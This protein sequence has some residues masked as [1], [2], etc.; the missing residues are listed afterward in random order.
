C[1]GEKAIITIYNSETGMQ[2]QLVDEDTNYIGSPIEGNGNNLSLEV[3]SQDNQTYRVL[4]RPN[5]SSCQVF[6]EQQAGIVVIEQPNVDVEIL[7]DDVCPGSKETY[8]ITNSGYVIDWTTSGGTLL[9]QSDDSITIAWNNGNSELITGVITGFVYDTLT[10]CGDTIQ[11]EI[12]ISDMEPPI[13]VCKEETEVNASWQGDGYYYQI[14]DTSLLPFTTDNCGEVTLIFIDNYGNEYPASSWIGYKIENGE[15]IITWQATDIFGQ[16]AQ[17]TTTIR[18]ND[19]EYIP[20]A[21]SPNGDG[22]NDTWEIPF[23]RQE[24]Y[25]NAIVKVYNQHGRLVFESKNGYSQYWDG[26]YNG[27]N[28]PTDSYHYVIILKN[29]KEVKK[30]TVSITK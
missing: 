5:G 6:M 10:N 3:S 23:L 1:Y 16:R 15:N 29:Q 9:Y 28:L 18:L 19:T 7:T 2:Y 30:G 17:C 21:F 20:S 22:V 13:I 8:Y 11:K 4:V 27:S 26:T 24:K 25:A 12:M 14:E